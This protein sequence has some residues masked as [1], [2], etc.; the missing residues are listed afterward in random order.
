MTA[1]AACDGLTNPSERKAK[2]RAPAPPRAR[3]RLRSPLLRGEGIFFEA[4]PYEQSSL[5]GVSALGCVLP[6]KDDHSAAGARDIADRLIASLGSMLVYWYHYS[7]AGKRIDVES[8]DDSIGGHFLHLLHGERPN[9]DWVHAMHTSLIL[10]AEHEFNASTFA[11]R[12]IAGTGA[13]MYS[14]IAGAIGTLRGPKHGGAMEVAFE[15]SSA[16]NRPTR[17]SRTSAHASPTRE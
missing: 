9:R 10:Y 12:V 8:E 5:S 1:F 2:N 14:A 15:F 6:E 13:D 16:T 17:P 7:H 11:A 4:P 3:A